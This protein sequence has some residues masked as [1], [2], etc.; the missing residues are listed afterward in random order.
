M[1]LTR[2]MSTWTEDREEIILEFDGIHYEAECFQKG[3]PAQD[4]VSRLHMLA[5]RIRRRA[6]QQCNS[7]EP[8]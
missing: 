4:V 7:I 5:E 1:K 3:T 2:I 8:S 6:Q